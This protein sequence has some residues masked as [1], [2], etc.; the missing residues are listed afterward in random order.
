[1]LKQKRK[2]DLVAVNK[3]QPQLSHTVPGQRLEIHSSG[4]GHGMK[5]G[6]AT[7]LLLLFSDSYLLHSSER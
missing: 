2:G 5:L 4:A 1:M 3:P 7:S 6:Q